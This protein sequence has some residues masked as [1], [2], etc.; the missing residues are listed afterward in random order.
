MLLW[1]ADHGVPAIAEAATLLGRAVGEQRRFNADD[2]ALLEA[3]C[4]ALAPPPSLAGP[5][6]RAVD[7]EINV[8]D[9]VLGHLKVQVSAV[10]QLRND[11]AF[12]EGVG[13][14][15]SHQL[16]K[17]TFRHFVP[18]TPGA[19]WALNLAML[20]S[21]HPETACFRRYGSLRLFCL[22]RF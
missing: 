4:D 9:A 22:G 12:F 5:I 15:T 3:A 13:N 2:Q 6:G 20:A 11:P 1:L 17:G 7:M 10:D 14:E 19:A 16:P 8:D 21:F 18:S